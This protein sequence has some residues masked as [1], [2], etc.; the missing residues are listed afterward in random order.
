MILD[1]LSNEKLPLNGE[2]RSFALPTNFN[3]VIKKPSKYIDIWAAIGTQLIIRH[4]VNIENNT[5]NIEHTESDSRAI[6]K[7][8]N[9]ITIRTCAPSSNIHI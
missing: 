8:F 5:Q 4:I 6:R 3:N 1:K 2:A 9:L 7:N